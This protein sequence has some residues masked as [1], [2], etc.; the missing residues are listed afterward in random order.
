MPDLS[1]GAAATVS[2]SRSRSRGG[3]RKRARG[4]SLHHLLAG[5][6]RQVD[7]R[8]R[9][10]ILR[11]RVLAPGRRSPRDSARGPSRSSRGRS[12][13]TSYAASWI[14]RCSVAR[15]RRGMPASYEFCAR[16]SS[17]ASGAVADELGDLLADL[18]GEALRI[19]ARLRGR[20]RSGTSPPSVS[21]LNYGRHVLR[22]LLVIDEALVEAAR[23]AVAQHRG[24][25]RPAPAPR[26]C[27]A[28]DRATSGT[29]A[30]TWTSSVVLITI[31]F[32]IGAGVLYCGR[33][34]SAPLGIHAKYFSTCFFTSS[35]F[36][37]PAITIVA[38]FGT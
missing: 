32:V 26:S 22:D 38:L 5:A 1:N 4:A 23:L 12:L 13:N 31:S 15:G 14:A 29:R 34:G 28:P 10:Q 2:R 36:T 21:P 6:D 20:R 9:L 3:N 27:S 24:R 11:R 33:A 19:D 35:N 18:L 30:G 37:S 7:A 17:L 16:S 8:V 25:D